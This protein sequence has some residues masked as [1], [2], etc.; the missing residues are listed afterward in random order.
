MRQRIGLAAALL[1]HP[2]VLFLDEPVSS[3]DP[4]GRHDILDVVG[5]LRGSTTVF[6]STHILNDVER[7]CDRVGILDRGRLLVEGPID[8]LLERHALPVYQLE[9]EPDQAAAVATLAARL[10]VEPWVTDVVDEHGFL[11]I[12]V[13]EPRAASQALLGILATAGVAI[14]GFERQRPSLEDVFLHLVAEGRGQ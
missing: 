14:V 2:D 11:R 9:P 13:R 12:H 8:D 1:N 5:R 10:R 4:A 3:L 7:V 6:M